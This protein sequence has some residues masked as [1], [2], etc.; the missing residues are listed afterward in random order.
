[1]KLEI[2]KPTVD[3]VQM[4]SAKDC[5]NF[6]KKYFTYENYKILEQSTANV[7][8]MRKHIITIVKWHT[9]EINTHI[10][11]GKRIL[12][13]TNKTKTA[14]STKAYNIK[15]KAENNY[16]E[17]PWDNQELAQMNGDKLILHP[18]FLFVAELGNFYLYSTR[19]AMNDNGISSY[20][21]QKV[22]RIRSKAKNGFYG[23]GLDE[24]L[25]NMTTRQIM[26]HPLFTLNVSI[27]KANKDKIVQKI[28]KLA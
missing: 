11:T 21:S 27:T 3:Q 24:Q 9:P 23:H 2:D 7:E 28:L 8:A 20:E 5:L 13:T 25:I 4:Y 16:Y 17:S 1:M 22:S 26:I 12:R 6:Y 19:S 10:I 14:V 18:I 15:K